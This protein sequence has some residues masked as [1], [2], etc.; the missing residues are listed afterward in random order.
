MEAS[1]GSAEDSKQPNYDNW[2]EYEGEGQKAEE[3]MVELIALFPAM[4][5]KDNQDEGGGTVLKASGRT[6]GL[7]L[8]GKNEEWEPWTGKITGMILEREDVILTAIMTSRWLLDDNILRA[9]EV[10]KTDG[11]ILLT[12]VDGTQSIMKEERANWG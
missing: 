10:L 12:K 5:I 4:E 11:W 8:H 2:K 7:R 3:R 9:R 1:Q 6:T